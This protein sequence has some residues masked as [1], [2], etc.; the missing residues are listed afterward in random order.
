MLAL[1]FERGF[2]KTTID[3]ILLYFKEPLRLDI[4]VPI[5]TGKENPGN[6]YSTDFVLNSTPLPKSH[7]TFQLFKYLRQNT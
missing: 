1:N 7:A 3:P 4:S 6:H 2:T 5:P